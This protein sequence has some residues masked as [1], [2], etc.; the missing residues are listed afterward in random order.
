MEPG[1]ELEAHQPPLYYLGL[2]LYQRAAGYPRD[3]LP[4]GCLAALGLERLRVPLPLRFVGPVLG[5]IG[6]VIAIHRDV[7]NVYM[8]R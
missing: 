5:L 7:V 3:A 8:R 1:A 4:S 6:T 2:A